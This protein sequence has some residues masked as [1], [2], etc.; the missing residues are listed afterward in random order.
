MPLEYMMALGAFRFS[1]S[2]ASYQS[3]LHKVE[4]RWVR[5]DVI[6]AP[7][8]HQY[9]GPGEQTIIMEGIIYPHHKGGLHQI[10]LM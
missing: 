2:T 7:P 3:F 10:A 5:Q 6:G 9:L 1:L 4:H 8:R